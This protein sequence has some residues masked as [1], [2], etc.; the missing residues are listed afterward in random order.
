MRIPVTVLIGTKGVRDAFYRV[1]NRDGKV[2]CRVHL[3]LVAGTVVLVL[4]I[5]TINDGIP[6]G[7]VRVIDTHF[8]ADAPSNS[9]L[10]PLLHQLEDC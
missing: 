3:P 7:L 6:H 4:H 9:F 5:A 10:C 8:G 2:I 1:E